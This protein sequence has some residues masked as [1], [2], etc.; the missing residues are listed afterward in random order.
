VVYH[1]LAL[2]GEDAV[3]KMAVELQAIGAAWP[4]HISEAMRDAIR[5]SQNYFR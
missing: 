2:L 1:D 4:R 5:D 3:A